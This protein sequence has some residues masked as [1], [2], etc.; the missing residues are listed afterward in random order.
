MAPHISNTITLH[1]S[2]A[3]PTHLPKSSCSSFSIFQNPLTKYSPC[4]YGL[5]YIGFHSMAV[6]G[7]VSELEEVL[8]YYVLVY[9][10]Q[11]KT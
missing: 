5:S 4:Q 10:P 7:R 3:M 6:N 11:K 9:I 2:V 8:S 1:P